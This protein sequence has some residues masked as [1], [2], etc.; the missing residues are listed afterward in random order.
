MNMTEAIAIVKHELDNAGIKRS[1]VDPD[2]I[3]KAAKTIIER[4]QLCIPLKLS[5]AGYVRYEVGHILTGET[6]DYHDVNV[7]SLQ[8]CIYAENHRQW[9]WMNPLKS[10]RLG[11]TSIRVWR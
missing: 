9:R 5:P 6:W 10:R 4:E 8:A 2:E 3:Y 1:H 11:P 7:R